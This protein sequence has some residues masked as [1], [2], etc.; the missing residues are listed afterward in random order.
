MK[1]Q[2][3]DFKRKC[4]KAEKEVE[5][6]SKDYDNALSSMPSGWSLL[7]MKVVEGLSSVVSEGLVLFATQG[8]S[9]ADKVAS[10]VGSLANNMI[11]KLNSSGPRAES[12]QAKLKLKNRLKMELKLI[13][14]RIG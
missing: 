5:K 14:S 4:E 8:L 1:T 2:K 7:G 11:S 10:K 12:T 9:T 3:E 13:H 6:R